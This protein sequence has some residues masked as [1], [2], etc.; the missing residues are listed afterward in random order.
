MMRTFK[1][2][3]AASALAG[4][5][6]LAAAQSAI[7]PEN[8]PNSAIQSDGDHHDHDVKGTNGGV[9]PYW[10]QGRSSSDDADGGAAVQPYDAT[11][12]R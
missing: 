11:T 9:P 6:S 10:Y 8:Q 5:V 3:V 2:I 7:A 1:I 4:S 12:G